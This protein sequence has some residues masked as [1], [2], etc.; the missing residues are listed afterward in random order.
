M[1]GFLSGRTS[2]TTVQTAD[3][4]A[5]AITLAK[6]AAG[7]DGNIISYDASGN[8]VAIATGSDGQALH[9]AG[10]GAQPA[11]ETVSAGFTQATEQATTSGT[12]VTFSSIPAG[13]KMITISLMGVVSNS[14]IDLTVVL[15]DAGGLEVS[16]YLMSHS[17]AT[18][19]TVATELGD[20]GSTANAFEINKQGSADIVHGTMILTLAD[21]SNVWTQMHVMSNSNTNKTYWGGGQKPLSGELTQIKVGV[22]SGAFTAGSANI[23]YM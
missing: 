20:A 14:D 1:S 23:S 5:D 15:G 13:V 22:A 12:G 4:A 10:A 19:A 9:S 8:P 18:S 7:T 2:L 11:F 17:N 3:I 6:M 16:G 21:A